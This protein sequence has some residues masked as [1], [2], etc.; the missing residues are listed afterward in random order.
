MIFSS[1]A[2]ALE[3]AETILSIREGGRSNAGMM[4]QLGG[5]AGKDYAVLDAIE[6]RAAAER[7]C[8][9]SLP[10]PLTRQD[11]LFLWLVFESCDSH[12]PL[13]DHQAD[14]IREC[15]SLF[16][17]ILVAK[18]FMEQATRMYAQNRGVGRGRR[19]GNAS[20]RGDG[21]NG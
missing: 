12:C 18:G 5:G 4:E 11:C 17:D 13:S 16:E 3:W 15:A 19:A 6:I 7:A 9:G 2:L 20:G 8:Q 21:R 14:R 1:A 10:C